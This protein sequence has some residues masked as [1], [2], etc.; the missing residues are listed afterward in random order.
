VDGVRRCAAKCKPKRDGTFG[1]H[2]SEHCYKRQR[3]VSTG[4]YVCSDDATTF[5]SQDDFGIHRIIQHAARFV[6]LHSLVP[7]RTRT[8]N[9]RT[10][11]TTSDWLL[12]ASIP[13]HSFYCIFCLYDGD[14]EL[15]HSSQTSKLMP[16]LRS[17]SN[18]ASKTSTMM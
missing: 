14:A 17:S 6:N 10:T 12:T 2:F 9:L 7:T 5:S 1:A 15:R 4:K 16:P 18:S 11:W 8:I 13:W 3:D